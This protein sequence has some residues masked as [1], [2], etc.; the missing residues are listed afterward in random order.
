MTAILAGAVV[1]LAVGC[2][3]DKKEVEEP[4]VAPTEPA[5]EPE[6]DTLIPP[7]KFDAI[8]SFFE[9]KARVVSRCYSE[10]VGSGDLGKN[11]KGFV[12][13]QMTITASGAL[14]NMQVAESNLKS[15]KL[16]RCLIDYLEKW[17]VTTLPKSL[18]Y[19]Y[20]FSFSPL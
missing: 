13:L 1:G 2:G 5:P 18:D 7:E 10:A 14:S 8:Q 12:T 15:D 3:G 17:T 4:L 16:H 11:A 6:E 9:R 20:T 19:S